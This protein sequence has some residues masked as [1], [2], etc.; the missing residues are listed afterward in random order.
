MEFMEEIRPVRF[1]HSDAVELSALAQA[2]YLRRYGYDDMTPLHSGHFDPPH[3][4][5]LVA[6]LGDVPVACGG[7]RAQVEGEEGYADGDAEIKRMF[8][9]PEARGR[10]LAR[11]VL[12]ALEDSARA[13]GRVRM[14]LE[15]G[16]P[17][18]EAMALYV[19]SGYV[20]TSNFG[21]YRGYSDSRCFAKRLD[22][23][24]GPPVRHRSSTSG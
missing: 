7:W 22:S 18:W 16:T 19:S 15:T 1:D 4:L 11:R 10:G 14:V 23:D 13:A 8:V 17:L 5:F 20:P 2:E 12:R 6:Y 9:V 24:G 21:P 3:G